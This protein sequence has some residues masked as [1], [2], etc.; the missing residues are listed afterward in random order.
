MD[1]VKSMKLLKIIGSSGTKL[2]CA[3]CGVETPSTGSIGICSN[4]ESMIS[5]DRKSLMGTNP[6]LVGDLDAIRKGIADKDFESAISVYGKMKSDEPSLLYA[7]ALACIGYSNCEISQISYDRKG[8]MEEN[9]EHR[10]KGS[11][12]ASKAK[13]L[14]AKATH[15]AAHDVENG[16]ASMDLVYA[17]FLLQVKLGAL[18]GASYTL[19]GLNKAGGVYALGYANIVLDASMKRYDDV[20]KHADILAG[21]NQLPLSALYYIAL[22]LFKKGRIADSTRLLKELQPLMTNQNIGPLLEEI[23][24]TQEV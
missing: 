4:C 13:L 22:A 2:I 14:I 19:R 24:K 10:R 21:G 15:L 11:E 12:L 5:M 1:A 20:M 16:S 7:E 8:F 9:A 17:L 6:E 3:Y 18:R 23:K